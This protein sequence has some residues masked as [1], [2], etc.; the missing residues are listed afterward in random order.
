MSLLIHR[1][2]QMIG[3]LMLTMI[4]LT[5][6]CDFFSHFSIPLCNVEIQMFAS[7]RRKTSKSAFF[8]RSKKPFPQSTA[9]SFSEVTM[10]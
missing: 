2:R 6:H 3:T 10:K 1:R 5:A 9:E 4:L 7:A 8:R